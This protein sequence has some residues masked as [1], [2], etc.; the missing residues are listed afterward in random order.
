M[1]DSRAVAVLAALGHGMRLS[2]WRLLAQ[3]G[4]NGLSAGAIAARMDILPSSLS[5]HLRQMTQAGLLVQRRSSRQI[6]YAADK[7][8][9]DDL[10]AFLATPFPMTTSVLLDQPDDVV[11]ER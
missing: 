9:M 6:I 4:S 2:L 1:G 8:T 7:E 3:Y 10:M 5:F 11:S